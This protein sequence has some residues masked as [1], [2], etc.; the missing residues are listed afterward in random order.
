MEDDTSGKRPPSVPAISI[1]ILNHD[2]AA[3]T[4][5]C[6]QS[7]LE[8]PTGES[9]E[10]IAVDNG[11]RD[12]TP[13]LLQAFVSAFK[14]IGVR[15]KVITHQENVGA[16]VGRN[17]A[18]EVA[19]GDYFL[20]LDNDVLAKDEGWLRTLRSR[21]D[22]HPSIAIVSP[23]LLFP[24]KPHLIECAGCAVSPSGRIQYRGRGA[25]RDAAEFN[26]EQEV[27]CLISACILFRRKLVE[28]IGSLD[29]AF[30]PVQYEDLDF[31]YRAR[32]AGY[33][34]L[35]TPCVEMYHF[36]H[37]TTAGSRD[38]N[39][40]YVT[41]KNGLLFKQRW[42]HMFEHENGPPDEECLWKPIPKKGIEQMNEQEWRTDNREQ[43]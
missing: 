32:Q 7:L 43:R 33:R 4:R 25:S 10:I 30:N 41:I 22:S 19:E 40:K 13:A 6:L 37:T 27:Q 36:E 11:S 34:V 26:V 2:K 42:R 8:I 16:I 14:Q 15:M 3:Y 31:C 18:M 12:Q 17:Q 21:L 1:I 28:E 23:K 29:E 35:Y 20:F 5:A 38:I 9:F 39:F 24:W